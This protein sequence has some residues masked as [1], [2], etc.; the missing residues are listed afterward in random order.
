M[1]KVSYFENQTEPSG[2][3]VTLDELKAWLK[4]DGDDEDSELTFILTVAQEKIEKYIN[5]A[6]RPYTVAGFFVDLQI[7]Q[8]EKWPFI[9]FKRFPVRSLT[10]VKAWDGDSYEDVLAS[11]YELKKRSYGFDRVVFKDGLSYTNNYDTSYP[12]RVEAEVGYADADSVPSV[13]KMAIR[14]YAAF[15]YD[16]RGDCSE[17]DC[18]SDGLPSMPKI[19]RASL[20]GY[21]LREAYA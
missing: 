20:K 8:L 11:D 10:S 21:K 6:L 9:S 19:V 3:V 14:Q 12:I 15:L 2:L 5:Q 13:I 17:C 1:K 4:I 18:D 16:N 7:N